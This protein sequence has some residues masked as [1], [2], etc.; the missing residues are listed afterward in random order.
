MIL[1]YTKLTNMILVLALHNLAFTYNERGKYDEAIKSY[2]E[3]LVLQRQLDDW[4]IEG[5]STS[6]YIKNAAIF[7]ICIVYVEIFE[8]WVLKSS[9]SMLALMTLAICYRE[10][11]KLEKS[12]SFMEEAVTIRRSYYSSSHPSL[13][14]GKK[15]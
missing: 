7:N 1:L 3:S 13:A 6:M 5:M 14:L 4:D 2:E 9:F 8:I 11:G 12:L 10:T 15:Y